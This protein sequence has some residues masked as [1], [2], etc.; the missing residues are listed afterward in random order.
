MGIRTPG[1]YIGNEFPTYNGDDL[2]WH[3]LPTDDF[4]EN[5]VPQNRLWGSRGY[6]YG[7]WK[8]NHLYERRMANKWPEPPEPEQDISTTL[9]LTPNTV[10]FLNLPIVRIPSFATEP[11]FQS[12]GYGENGLNIDANNIE[13]DYFSYR[14]LKFTTTSISNLWIGVKANRRRLCDINIGQIQF[15]NVS[16]GSYLDTFNS[17]TSGPPTGTQSGNWKYILVNGDL[18]PDNLPNPTATLPLSSPTQ[19]QHYWGFA[20]QR[21]TTPWGSGC[22][23]GHSPIDLNNYSAGASIP[24]N[25]NL[26]EN[27]NLSFRSGSFS[28]RTGWLVYSKGYGN[29]PVRVSMTLC[30][31]SPYKY[32]FDYGADNDYIRIFYQP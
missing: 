5:G 28:I 25:R 18:D 13:T 26:S 10:H 27:N 20:T 31:I 32:G 23:Y 11:S 9:A 29:V 1:S 30:M 3:M 17:W 12:L 22:K 6:A 2:C 16:T 8:T 21:T 15:N 24:Q 4:N 19:N 7:V 14:V